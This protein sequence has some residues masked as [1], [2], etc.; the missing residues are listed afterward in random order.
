MNLFAKGSCVIAT[1]MTDTDEL[2]RLVHVAVGMK[3]KSIRCVNT[4]MS[5]KLS[6][7][8][9]LEQLFDSL[10]S[11]EADGAAASV[12]ML[13]SKRFPAI[14][15]KLSASQIA[16]E[17]YHTGNINLTGM[18]LTKDVDAARQYIQ[19]HIIPSI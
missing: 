7:P 10:T 18:K 1:R 14:V 15:V 3:P 8:I 13:D 6:K 12:I 5:F 11:N 2:I 16:I 4:T 9:N 19:E 17:L